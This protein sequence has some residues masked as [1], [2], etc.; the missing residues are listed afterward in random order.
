MTEVVDAIAALRDRLSTPRRIGTSIALVPTMGALHRGHARLIETAR[1]EC[2]L[3]V[4]SIFVN[5]LQFDRADDL[6]RY[7]RTLDADVATCASSGADI[8]F[9]PTAA[10]MY[11]HEPAFVVEVRG[12]GDHLCGRFRPGHF[13]G[14]AT[15][16]L[17]LLHIAQPDRAYFGEKDAQQ[18]AIIRRMVSDLDVPTTIVGVPTVRE[19]DGLALSSRNRLLSA[20]ERVRAVALVRLLTE[21]QRLIAAGTARADDVVR[22]AAALVPAGPGI[23][24]E[25]LEIV[26]PVHLQPVSDITSP[27]LVAG[28]M[29]VGSVRL[30][31]NV[32]CRRP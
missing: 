6:A 24:L 26:D 14:V 11:P 27:V 3:L 29:W 31:D 17:K 1:A 8:V 20:E 13:V 25:Y 28:A 22:Q 32:L 7:P 23:R 4:V 5:P 16:V 15:V 9:A 18:L 12:L 21:A 30:I 2:D 19:P 10:D